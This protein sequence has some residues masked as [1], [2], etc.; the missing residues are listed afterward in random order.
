MEGYVP[1]ETIL[2]TGA[3]KVM[4]SK[5]FAAAM[6]VNSRNLRRGVEFVTASGAIEMPLGT[7]NTKLKFTLA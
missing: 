5:T 6:Q 3:A 7:T 2:D 1:K 4:L